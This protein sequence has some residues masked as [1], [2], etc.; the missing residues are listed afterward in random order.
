[1]ADQVAQALLCYGIGN[2]SRGDDGLGPALINW[3]QANAAEHPGIR[4]TLEK[5]F[6]L[7]PEN[8]YDFAGQ[9][10]L[11]F[12]DADARFQQGIRFSPLEADSTESPFVSH[13]LAPGRLLKM[14][15]DLLKSRHPRA[16]LLSM[17]AQSTGLDEALSATAKQNLALAKAFLAELLQQP[18]SI[19][20]Q[21][22]T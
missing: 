5:P 13:A 22:A 19:W 15:N 1:M 7:Q 21:Q 14:H 10:A 20:P 18:I 9:D 17:G 4:L 8:I 11:L 3:L 6:Q 2:E 16:F 12:L